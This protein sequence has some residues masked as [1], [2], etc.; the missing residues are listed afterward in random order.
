MGKKKGAMTVEA[1]I[2]LPLYILLLTFL[3]NFLNVYYLHTVVQHGLN[4]AASTLAQ[5]CYA[6]D[7]T[8]GIEKLSLQEETSAKAQELGEAINGFYDAST[9]ALELFNSGLTL[10]NL[11]K[12][13]SSG[14]TFIS[15]SSNLVSKVRGVTGDDVAN[16]VL[17]GMVETGGGMLV[18]AMVDDYLDQMKIDRGLLTGDIRYGLYLTSDDRHDLVLTAEYEYGDSLF[19]LFTD[20]FSIR[21][22]AVVHPWIG[23]STPGLRGGG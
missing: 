14:Q 7:L 8:L 21:Q 16:L 17:T 2:V 19:A 23:G 15:A 3:A 22:Q 10:D 13:L 1:A 6:V 4:S 9:D 12:L 18:E 20:G 5:Y 11:P